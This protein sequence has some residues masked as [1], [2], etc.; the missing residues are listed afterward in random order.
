[1][2]ADA[3]RAVQRSVA[4]TIAS[5]VVPR[6]NRPSAFQIEDMRGSYRAR[7]GS[8]GDGAIAV[9]IGAILMMA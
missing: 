8:Y 1:M 3:A 6:M 2:D 4:A 5:G 9:T 7:D